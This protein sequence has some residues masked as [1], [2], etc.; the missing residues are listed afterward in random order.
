MTTFISKKMPPHAFRRLPLTL[1][2]IALTVPLAAT[3]AQ[4]E[5]T[6]TATVVSMPQ[7]AWSSKYGATSLNAYWPD[8]AATYWSTVYPVTPG[9]EITIS[10]VFPDAR[11]ASFNVYDDKPTHFT[12]SGVTSNLPDYLIAPDA[13]SFNPWRS[14]ARPGG[15]FTLTLAHDVAVGQANRLPLAREDALPGTKA[16][17]IFRVYLPAGGDAN[18]VLPTM[19]LTRNGIS[20]TLPLCSSGVAAPVPPEAASMAEDPETT[21]A[22]GSETPVLPGVPGLPGETGQKVFTRTSEVENLAPNADNAYLGTWVTP[23]TTDQVTVIRGRAPRAVSGDHPAFWPR[24]LADLRYW[25]MCT[26]LGGQLKPVVINRFPDAP[27]SYGCRYDDD[28][29]LDRFG[30]YTYVLGREQQ[31]AAIE[32]IDNT[33]FLP[34]SASYPAAPHMVLLRNLLPDA[35]F[36]HATKNVPMDSPAETA[37]TVMGPYYP[38]VKVCSLAA[39]AADGPRRCTP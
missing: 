11:Y 25:S 16:S 12:R 10:G 27:S 3:P 9:L 13:G 31:R 39:L 33:T 32:A 2:L 37:A 7:C 30:Y 24:P 19:T 29:R 18:V 26:N 28:T 22:S 21:I 34:F 4:A 5:R 8:T 36:P 15:R 23:P 14:P 38:L 6:A 20:Q 35:D 17:V 1:T